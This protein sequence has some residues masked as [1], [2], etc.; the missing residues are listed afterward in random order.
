[1]DQSKEKDTGMNS[2]L[3]KKTYFWNTLSGM[4]NAGQSALILFFIMHFSD[5]TAGGI[6]SISFSFANLF[7][8]MAKYATRNYQLTDIEEKK[9]LME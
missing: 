6:F 3:I 2:N 8:T 5:A 4:L 9:T 1:M 7:Y